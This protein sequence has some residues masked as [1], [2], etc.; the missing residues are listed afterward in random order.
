[1]RA[2]LSGLDKER[3][4]PEALL[5]DQGHQPAKGVVLDPKGNAGKRLPTKKLPGIWRGGLHS[6]RGPT[7]QA[8]C[9]GLQR[10][11]LFGLIDLKKWKHARPGLGPWALVPHLPLCCWPPPVG[12]LV[13]QGVAGTVVALKDE[14]TLIARTYKYMT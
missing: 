11:T 6:Q 4:L 14:S 12:Q 8:G 3:S 7:A 10:E 2:L 5:M 13:T 9:K 1:M